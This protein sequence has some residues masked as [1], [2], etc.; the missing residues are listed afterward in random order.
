MPPQ[1]TIF[2]HPLARVR[3][4]EGFPPACKA[5]GIGKRIRR[6][7]INDT[8]W[9]AWGVLPA[10]AVGGLA[11]SWR[12]EGGRG[13]AW[14][15]AGLGQG[16]MAAWLRERSEGGAMAGGGARDGRPSWKP[17]APRVC[18]RLCV[19]GPGG[20]PSFSILLLLYS[21][22]LNLHARGTQP[23]SQPPSCP[24]PVYI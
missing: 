18:P 15:R 13:G 9:G 11:T 14:P 8:R 5:D 19:Q 17:A 24:Y 20:T 12:G 22:I 23:P 16:G 6:A 21:P 3:G 2:G 4:R 1:S 10:Q 7:S